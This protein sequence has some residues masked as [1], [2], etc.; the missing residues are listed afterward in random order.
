MTIKKSLGLNDRFILTT[1]EGWIIGHSLKDFGT[2]T[3]QLSK[4]H[5]SVEAENNLMKIGVIQR[6]RPFSKNANKS[7]FS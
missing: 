2:K 4:M 5:S 3:S 6:Q 1:C 7:L